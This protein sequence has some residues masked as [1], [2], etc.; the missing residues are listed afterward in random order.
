MDDSDLS[1]P[2]VAAIVCILFALDLMFTVSQAFRQDT[3][4]T[5]PC[6]FVHVC[7]LSTT[8]SK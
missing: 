1:N 3:C 2:Q 8:Q 4:F 7:V 6:V 5:T